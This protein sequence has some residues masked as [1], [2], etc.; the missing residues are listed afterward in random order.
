MSNVKVKIDYAGVGQLLKSAEMK[1]LVRDYADGIAK[2][3]GAGFEVTDYTGKSR[4]NASVRAESQE[5]INACLKDN[6]LI[7]A[8]G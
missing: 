5:A 7:K 6:V 4:V 2:K 3:V 1:A 8:V